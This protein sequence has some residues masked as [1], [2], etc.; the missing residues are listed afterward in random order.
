MSEGEGVCAGVSLS[1]AATVAAS[2]GSVL[3]SFIVCVCVCV[4]VC[5]SIGKWI[6]KDGIYF[7]S[8]SF[9]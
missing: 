4:C 7:A 8:A 6:G 1:S 9:F 3:V 2:K 5:V